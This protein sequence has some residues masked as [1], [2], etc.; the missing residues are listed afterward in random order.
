MKNYSSKKT[1]QGRAAFRTP[2]KFLAKKLFGIKRLPPK[3]RLA[4]QQKIPSR[5]PSRNEG[6]GKNK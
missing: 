2:S 4:P 3:V 1:N 5:F 6:H